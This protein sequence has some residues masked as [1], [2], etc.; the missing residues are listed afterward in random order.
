MARLIMR[1][2]TSG[3]ATFMARSR[4]PK[5][6]VESCQ[7]CRDPLLRMTCKTGTSNSCHSFTSG[8]WLSKRASEKLVVLSNTQSGRQSDPEGLEASPGLEGYRCKG[9]RAA[10][11]APAGLWPKHRWAGCFPLKHG[12]G[13]AKSPP[14]EPG[15]GPAERREG[16]RPQARQHL[17]IRHGILAPQKFPG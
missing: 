3:K 11:P 6:R 13:R 8:C 4:A 14:W 2:S 9:K 17:R 7:L 1:P 16:G 10:T 12:P 15:K 5:P